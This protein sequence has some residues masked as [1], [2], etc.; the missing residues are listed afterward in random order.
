MNNLG[1]VYEAEGKDAEDVGKY[2][3]AATLYKE[4]LDGRRRILGPE[5]PDTL[6]S[7]ADLASIYTRGGKDAQAEPLFREV[8]DIERR[9]LGP[10]HPETVWTLGG[11]AVACDNQGNYAQAEP[12]FH[13]A[14]EIAR[15]V[16]GPENPFTLS[17]INNL[18]AVYQDLGQFDLAETYNAQALAGQRHALG[19][20]N[21][22]TMASASD[23]A[24]AYIS[25][26]KF[27]QAEPLARE[28]LETDKKVQPDDW[29]RFRAASLLGASLAGEKRY[30]EAEPLLLEGY[31]GM[32]AR[33]DRM[34]AVPDRRQ[35]DRAREW[36]V[37]LYEEEGKPDKAAAWKGK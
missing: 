5:H 15:R 28:A 27:A 31:Q 3:Q 22:D 37:Q 17:H 33:K 30:V 13:Q 25:Q 4:S 9:I 21:P 12:L 11:L 34:P 14:V 19:A 26:G 32:V 16:L 29:E 18:G 23:L 7:M 2:A 35:I 10:E 8:F 1:T 6:Q 24:L 36:I 20:Q